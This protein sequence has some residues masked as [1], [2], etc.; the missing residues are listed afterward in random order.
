MY[1]PLYLH[2]NEGERAGTLEQHTRGVSGAPDGHCSP[3]RNRAFPPGWAI[4][5]HRVDH[6]LDV[7]VNREWQGRTQ[8]Q[9]MQP[10]YGVGSGRGV[11]DNQ[12]AIGRAGQEL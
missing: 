8:R 1:I 6:L 3:S 7:L 11:V 10:V 2:I 9:H 5:N 4:C 12:A